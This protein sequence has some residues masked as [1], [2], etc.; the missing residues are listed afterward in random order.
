MAKTKTADRASV[1]DAVAQLREMLDGSRSELAAG[2][3]KAAGTLAI[4][5]AVRSVDLICDAALGEHSVAAS[6]SV[7]LDLLATVP[8]AETAIENFS[9]CQTHKTDYNYHITAV[10]D[11]EVVSVMEAAESLAQEARRRLK[12]KGWM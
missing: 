8:D 5:A 11:E 10:N 4:A 2:R 1:A 3:R 9:L 6:H 7:A 12:D